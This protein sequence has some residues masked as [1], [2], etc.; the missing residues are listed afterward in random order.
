LFFLI[1][2]TSKELSARGCHLSLLRCKGN[3]FFIHVQIFFYFFFIFFIPALLM[4]KCQ[5]FIKKLFLALRRFKII[6][7]IIST[8]IS[9]F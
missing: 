1:C 8:L 6:F 2:N 4:A 5:R 3:T 9:Q 7:R